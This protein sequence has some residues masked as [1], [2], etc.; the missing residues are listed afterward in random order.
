ME[1]PLHASLWK[2]ERDL[3]N[4]IVQNAPCRTGPLDTCTHTH[5]MTGALLLILS[6]LEEGGIFERHRVPLSTRTH[7]R[8]LMPRRVVAKRGS[9]GTPCRVVG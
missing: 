1:R 7:V 4:E 8:Y 5:A 3:V 2:R 9:A 6:V